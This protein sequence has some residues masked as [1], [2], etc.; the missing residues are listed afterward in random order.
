MRILPCWRPW[1]K[2]LA[3]WTRCKVAARVHCGILQEFIVVCNGVSFPE[4]I[5][6]LL[7]MLVQY[8]FTFKASE[9][10]TSFSQL[11]A[12][13]RSKIPSIWQPPTLH[14]ITSTQVHYSTLPFLSSSLLP[15]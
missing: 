6:S 4:E 2:R 10:Q 8:G 7:G 3:Q 11:L 12:T 15:Q 9:V 13:V 5:C 1:G 14:P